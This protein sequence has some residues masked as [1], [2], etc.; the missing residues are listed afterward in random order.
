MSAKTGSYFGFLWLAA[1]AATLLSACSGAVEK[2]PDPVSISVDLEPALQRL[3]DS[4]KIRTVSEGPDSP[5]AAPAFKELHGLLADRFPLVHRHLKRREINDLS[6]LYTWEGTDRQEDAILLTAHMDV[7]PPGDEWDVDPFGGQID[8]THLWGRGA[9]DDKLSVLGTLEAAELLLTHGLVPKRT[10]YFG[11]GHDEE[12]D[13]SGGAVKIAQY[14]KSQ[15]RGIE[16]AL[17]EGLVIGTEG[18]VAGI[19]RPVAM[20]GTAEKG[21]L[22]VRLEARADGGHSSVP[23]PE[24]AIDRLIAALKR[25]KESP[26]PTQLISPATDMLDAIAPELSTIEQIAIRNRWLLGSLLKGQLEAAPASNAMIRTTMV[27]TILKAGEKDNVIP[28]R[29]EATVNL[30]LLPGDTIQSTLE[31]LQTTIGDDTISITPLEG[32]NEPSSVSRSDSPAFQVVE[33]TI[34]EIFPDAIV[35]PSLVLAATDA[36]HY[37]SVAQDVYRF[38][39]VPLNEEDMARI[40]GANE[41][42]KKADYGK[43]I[44]F[45]VQ[46]LCNASFDLGACDTV[47]DK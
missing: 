27:P 10:I 34:Y 12:I 8:E 45:Y 40:H 28:S 35:A 7:V 39:P 2:R 47:Y 1:V 4:I 5:P 43:V 26:F 9:L 36:R 21:Y 23:G 17:D 29:A 44:A 37:E 41:R 11:F 42:I 32:A 3:S 16:F 18:L 24:T 22:S 19:Q 30:R 14:L 13:G 33:K 20:I 25:L 15:N 6:L 46:L 31:K 38:L